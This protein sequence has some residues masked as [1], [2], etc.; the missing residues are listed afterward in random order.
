MWVGTPT[1]PFT[2]ASP[3]DRAQGE[4]LRCSERPRSGGISCDTALLEIAASKV[5]LLKSSRY[6][7]NDRLQMSNA[8][9]RMDQN[10][11]EPYQ[12]HRE[13]NSREQPFAA[14]VFAAGQAVILTL[15]AL[16]LSATIT[17]ASAADPLRIGFQKTGTFAWLLDVIRRHDLAGD[18]GLKLD[19]TEFASPDAGKLALNSNA[20]DIAVADWFWVASERA[21][22]RKLQFYPYSS[23]IG[24]IM[25]KSDSPVRTLADLKGRTLAVA[26][27]PLDKS[28][29]ILRA[30]A[31]RRGIDLKRDVTLQYG[32]PP[33]LFQKMQQGES[34]ANLNFWNFCAKLE[35]RGYRRLFDV[36]DAEIELGLTEPVS[37][38]GYVFSQTFVASHRDVVDR[39][40]AVARRANQLLLHSDAE[41]DALR[42]LIDAEDDATF[43]AMRA[44]AKEGIPR[45]PVNEEEAD[46]SLL[47][48]ALAQIGG[49]ELVGPAKE[50]D[51]GLY[52][53]PI[54]HGE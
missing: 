42:P 1:A 47:F 17:P 13:T 11:R 19:V 3:S 54:S 52:Y 5:D 49:S 38:I 4:M 28:W 51:P 9:R 20:V 29:L 22:G 18:A 23:A 6:N 26:G 8:D 39:F 33:L 46:A 34:D 44:Y 7:S 27:G 10:G 30:A 50:L 45:R 40:L 16:L 41:W 36:R 24:A 21:L 2:A 53:H 12:T 48:H 31:L 35:A 43:N 32:A 25:V 37:V 15:L 14:R